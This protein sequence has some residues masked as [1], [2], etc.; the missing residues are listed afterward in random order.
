MKRKLGVILT[1]FAV[2]PLPPQPHS[3]KAECYLEL[4]VALHLRRHRALKPLGAT[5]AHEIICV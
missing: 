5:S 4:A 1:A 2:G 3:P